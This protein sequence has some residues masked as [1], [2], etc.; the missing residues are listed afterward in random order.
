MK[1]QNTVLKTTSMLIAA[2]M[3][4]ATLVVLGT[5]SVGAE[6]ATGSYDV[7][8]D[9]SNETAYEISTAA[10]LLWFANEV[11]GGNNKINGVLMNDIDLSTVCSATLG[12]WTPIGTEA[13]YFEGSFDG[14]GFTVK[15][16]YYNNTTEGEGED[17]GLFGNNWII[18]G[19]SYSRHGTKYVIMIVS[20]AEGL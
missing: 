7:N 9:G 14:R 4:I 2:L 8:G 18:C 11:N 3:L 12:N 15:N 10:D 6:P 16:L 19:S 5:V 13:N 1:K 20:L 17:V